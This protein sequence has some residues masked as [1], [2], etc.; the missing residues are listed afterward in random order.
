MG[1]RYVRDARGRFASSG[2]SGQT[3]G[4]GAR[5]K[6]KTQRAGGGAK[7]KAAGPADT[8]GKPRGLKP[9]SI[10]PKASS[11]SRMQPLRGVNAAVK[12][13]LS[14]FKGLPVVLRSKKQAAA[15]QRERNRRTFEF[16]R[17]AA[18][19]DGRRSDRGIKIK[20]TKVNQGNLLTGRTDRV[21]VRG[22]A[23]QTPSV[24]GQSKASKK[25][26]VRRARAEKRYEQ[27]IQ[28]R[29]ALMN[30]RRNPAGVVAKN[31]NRM[32]SVA[33]A[34]RTY[35]MGTGRKPPKRTTGRRK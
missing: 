32:A 15:A 29:K 2:Y 14:G 9:N 11:T 27:L 25:T 10:K 18:G 23:S 7:I 30:N 28:E 4:R 33:N 19:Y 24:I 20:T 6:A 8:V 17:S 13:N 16:S 3:G 21:V 1:R 22:A 12:G 26:Q 35:D 34:F 5:L 31:S